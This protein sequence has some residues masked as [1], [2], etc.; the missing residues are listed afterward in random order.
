MNRIII[1][2]PNGM[3]GSMVYRYFKNKKWIIECY[4]ERLDISNVDS[5]VRTLNRKRQSVIINC[6]GKIKQKRATDS[7]MLFSNSMFPIIL[8][9]KLDPKHYLV[10]AS[11]DCVFDGTKKGFYP[12]EYPH[13]ASDIYGISKSLGEN[14]LCCRA[15]TLIVRTSIIGVSDNPNSGL[16]G[17]FLSNLDDSEVCGYKDHF[18]NGIT[19]LE[20]CKIVEKIVVNMFG[21]N[22][23][24]YSNNLIQVGCMN[25][26]SKYDLLDMLNRIYCRNVKVKSV[27]NGYINRSLVSD[28]KVQNIEQQLIEL[29]RNMS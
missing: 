1:L 4:N 28:I 13:T 11:T 7:Q 8:G 20:W 10:H 24:A 16:L 21:S 15:N 26:I 29:R 23:I 2:G 17:W 9:K 3:L 14:A 19:T 22:K 25:R 5:F 12:K 18:W 27:T 6:L